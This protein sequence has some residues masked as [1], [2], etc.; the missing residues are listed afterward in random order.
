MIPYSILYNFKLLTEY[1]VDIKH[2]NEFP[3]FL[4]VQYIWPYL[5][6]IQSWSILTPWPWR[7]QSKKKNNNSSANLYTVGPRVKRQSQLKEKK[8]RQEKKKE[9]DITWQEITIR[10]P[11]VSCCGIYGKTWTEKIDGQTNMNEEISVSVEMQ[12][13]DKWQEQD[14]GASQRW[15]TLYKRAG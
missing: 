1:G 8:N 7:S 11:L 14:P 6:Q 5:H 15:Y 10:T 13:A 4:Y 3:R 2:V 9:Q 12:M